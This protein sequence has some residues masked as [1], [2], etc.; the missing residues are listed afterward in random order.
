MQQS[1][2]F[3]L[4]ELVNS[5]TAKKQGIANIPTWAQVENLNRLAL[6]LDAIRTRFGRAIMVSSGFRN[7]LLNHAVGGVSGSQ[8]TKGLA[9]DLQSNHLDELFELIEKG[10]FDYDQLIMETNGV[11]RWVH[12]SIPETGKK[13]RNQVLRINK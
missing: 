6:F 5:A 9:A 12:V 10:G 3:T 1:K 7:T 11:T 2:Y 4:Y 8:H 13:A